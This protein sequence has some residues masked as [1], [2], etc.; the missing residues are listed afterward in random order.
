MDYKET[1]GDNG[2]GHYLDFVMVVSR[3]HTCQ[4]YQIVHFKH[5]QLI[6]QQLYLS[7]A[8]FKKRARGMFQK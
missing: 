6:V 7:Q 8:A 3:V 1:L 2:F 4:T 5:G